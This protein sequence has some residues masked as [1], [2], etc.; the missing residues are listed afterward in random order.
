MDR[1]ADAAAYEGYIGR[2]SRRVAV[3]FLDWLAVPP[4]GRWL[5]VGCGSG[6]LVEAILS[7]SPRAVYGVDRSPEFAR[8]VAAKLAGDPRVHVCAGDAQSLPPDVPADLD[9]AVSGLVLNFV[10]EPARAL[11]EMARVARLVAVYVWDY[12]EGMELLR[13]FWDA[14]VALD[15]AAAALDEGVRFPLCRPDALAALFRPAV[16]DVEVRPIEVETRFR[17]FED[18]WSPFL[19]AQGPA[20]GYVAAL[21]EERRAAL[22]DELRARLG[23][24]PIGLRARAW[25]ARGVSSNRVGGRA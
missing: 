1:F 2:W 4:G 22:R 5:D 23:D 11:A 21:D 12:A 18:L 14:A 16:G 19:G 10:A 17:D 8:A 6:A 7:R 9:V 13:R 3:E 24:G 25:A 20:P 15:P